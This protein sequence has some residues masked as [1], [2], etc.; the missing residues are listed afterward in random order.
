[1]GEKS[2]IQWTDAT[3][4]P[5]QGCLKVS[6]GCKQ[7]YMY[8]DMKRYGRNP[9]VVVRS[10][11]TFDNPLKWARQGKTG[12]KVFT[13][14]WSDWF[15]DQADEWRGEAWDIIRQ[16]PQFIYQILTKRPENIADRL[17]PDWGNGWPN[18]WLG[19]SVESPEY[20]H[21]VYRLQQ[22]PAAVRFISYEPAIE[23]VSFRDVFRLGGIHWLIS[24]GESGY[25]PR[26]YDLDWFRL[27]R[28]DCHDFG[29][30][31]FH[32][33]HG[34]NRKV[35]GA[36]GGRKLDGVEYNGFPVIPVTL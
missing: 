17:P 32:K 21:R 31:Y 33:Q 35:D 18:V 34:G 5:W 8:R 15:I 16:T 27:A 36:W 11:T 30:T 1:M 9:R 7:C 22:I 12:T 25:D 3:W 24:G 14:S 2:E 26:P 23:Y 28:D 6:P 20:L 13:C 29:I 10:K 19:V 4:N